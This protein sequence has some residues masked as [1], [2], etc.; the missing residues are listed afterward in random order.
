MRSFVVL[1]SILAALL[2]W[3]FHAAHDQDYVTTVVVGQ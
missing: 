3:G 1:F 2:G